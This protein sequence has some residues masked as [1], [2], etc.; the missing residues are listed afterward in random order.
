ML[1]FHSE[2]SHSLFW[3]STHNFLEPVFGRTANLCWEQVAPLFQHQTAIIHYFRLLQWIFNFISLILD[4]NNL[5]DIANSILN[6]QYVCSSPQKT[7]SSASL[8]VLRQSVSFIHSPATHQPPA[9]GTCTAGS[10]RV[11]W[12][13]LHEAW[14]KLLTPSVNKERRKQAA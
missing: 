12:A 8:T 14:C 6:F 4:I 1:I 2:A 10:P 7:G 11:L 9:E 13:S 5:D 3:G